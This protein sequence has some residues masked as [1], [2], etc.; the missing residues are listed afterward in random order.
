LASLICTLIFAGHVFADVTVNI[1][2]VNGTESDR[3]KKVY[4]I[5]PQGIN[6]EDV[7]DTAG[8]KLEYNVEKNAYAV[9]GEVELSAKETKKLKVKMRD[10]WVIDE[11]DINDIRKQVDQNLERIKGTEF[12]EIG[13]IRKESLLNRLNYILES[14]AQYADKVEKRI[15]YFKVYADEIKNIRSD[16]ISIDFWKRKPP[17]YD[18]ENIITFIIDATNPSEDNERTFEHKHYLPPEV[19]P[20]HLVEIQGFDFR[21]D[22]LK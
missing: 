19:K 8:L 13:I 18:D 17:S 6:A 4:Y 10:I 7:L 22:P 14:Q 11:A 3:Q 5:L 20:E 2:A 9:A 1:L 15:D 12:Y 16:A 21:Y